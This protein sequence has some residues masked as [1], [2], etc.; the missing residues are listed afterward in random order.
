M[1][2]HAA[3]DFIHLAPFRKLI[4]DLNF[5]LRKKVHWLRAAFLSAVP[6]GERERD[7]SAVSQQTT[8]IEG[9]E[10]KGRR[11]KTAGLSTRPAKTTRRVPQRKR[12][13]DFAIHLESHSSPT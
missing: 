9:R 4:E 12:V 8:R 5:L 10:T 7:C 11:G 6:R 3:G 13:T 1:Q 2:A